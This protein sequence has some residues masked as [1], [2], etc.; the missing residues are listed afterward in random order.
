MDLLNR[1]SDLSHRMQQDRSVLH[2]TASLLHQFA[3][4]LTHRTQFNDQ[5]REVLIH[6]RKHQ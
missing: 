3:H 6:L 1:L 4:I 2:P 5:R